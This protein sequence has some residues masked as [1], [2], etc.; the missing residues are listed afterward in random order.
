MLWSAFADSSKRLTFA[1]QSLE[2][3]ESCKDCSDPNL[4]FSA[5]CGTPHILLWVKIQCYLPAKLLAIKGHKQAIRLHVLLFGSHAPAIVGPKD[6]YLYSQN[7]PNKK[8]LRPAD[9]KQ[10]EAANQ[11]N[12]SHIF[13]SS[14]FLIFVEQLLHIFIYVNSESLALRFTKQI[15]FALAKSA[16]LFCPPSFFAFFVFIFTGITHPH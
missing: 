7:V 5:V 9:L 6:V 13:S 8:V 3:Q 10:F 15:I 16:I 11:V 12:S 2:I 1:I 4:S 14:C